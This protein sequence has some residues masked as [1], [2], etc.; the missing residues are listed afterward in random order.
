MAEHFATRGVVV[1]TIDYLGVGDSS[2]PASI[3]G[4]D[5]HVAA[6][7]H[8]AAAAQAFALLKEGRLTSSIPALPRID[9]V[10]LAHSMGVMLQLTQQAR[11]RTYDKIALLGYSVVGV[12]LDRPPEAQRSLDPSQ[13][14]DEIVVDRKSLRRI[15]FLEDVPPEIIALDEATA[16]TVP[17]LIGLQAQMPNIVAEDVQAI[18]VP[19]F[20]ALGERDLSP[21][22]HEE[23]ARF[24]GTTDVAFLIVKGSAHNHN[25]ATTRAVLWD[26]ILTWIPATA[27]TSR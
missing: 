2:R 11:W 21:K 14:G 9:R 13:Y 20:F 25:F 23:T 5:R 3:K 7:A 1:L 16:V 10:G 27:P 17:S 4:I 26:R 18:D 22:P 24:T 19:V 8:H 6:A 15:F 12:T